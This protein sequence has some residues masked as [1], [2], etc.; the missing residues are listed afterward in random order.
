MK[1]YDISMSISENMQVYKN[2]EEKKPVFSVTRDFKTGNSFETNIKMDMHTGTHIDAPL[3]MIRDGATIDKVRLDKFISKCKVLDFTNVEDCIT[4]SNLEKKCIEENE[5]L[6]LK[7]RNSFK[8]CFDYNFVYLE[9]E[10]AQYLKEKKVKGVGIDALGIERNQ[11]GHPTHKI[12]LSSGI[13]II[14]GLRLKNIEEGKYII[15]ALPL[16]F[17]GVEASPVRAILIKDM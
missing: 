5:F 15:I 3:H 12:L 8:D 6:L 4:K 7:T 11:K 14:E 1:I 9:K 16:K 10:A 2:K 13:I 17:V